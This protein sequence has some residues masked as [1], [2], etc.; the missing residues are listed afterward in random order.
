MP[1][2]PL[3]PSRTPLAGRGR[4]GDGLHDPRLEPTDRVPGLLPFEGVP[5]G[6][7]FGSRTSR[8]FCRRH[9]CLSPSVGWS[10]FSRD[11]TPEG[12]QPAFAV[13]GCRPPA[14]GQPVA[15][16]RPPH[17]HGGLTLY[18]IHYRSALASSLIPPPLPHQRPLQSAFPH[19]EA[20]GLLLSSPQSLRGT[21]VP[22]GRW[23][24]IRDGGLT[25]PQYLTTSLLVQA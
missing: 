9:I 2:I 4:F 10:R 17:L 20:T 25:S 23:C 13:R 19:G 14:I 11:G 5:V 6:R 21:V 1:L 16:S 24:T 15:P 3:K 8:H 22:L 12:R 18:P 7:R